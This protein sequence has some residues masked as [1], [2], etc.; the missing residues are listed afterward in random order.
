VHA[1]FGCQDGLGLWVQS[2]GAG[3]KV[4]IRN[5]SVHDYQKDGI[6]ANNAGTN[7]T[8]RNNSVVGVGPNIQIAQNGIEISLGAQAEVSRNSVINDVYLTPQGQPSSPPAAS[9]FMPRPGLRLSKITSGILRKG[10]R[11]SLTRKVRARPMGG[12]E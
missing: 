5:S 7:V 4:K 9:W 10:S 8:V 1:L 11:S 12:G 2:S 3:S 6:E